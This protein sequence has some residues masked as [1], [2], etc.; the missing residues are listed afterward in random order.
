M[1][2]SQVCPHLSKYPVC[3]M[4]WGVPGASLSI[5]DFAILAKYA[6]AANESKYTQLLN[7]SFGPQASL[8]PGTFDEYTDF[9]RTIATRFH[10]KSSDTDAATI[11]ISVKGTSTN[12]DML[13]DLS[14]YTNIKMLQWASLIF[15]LQDDMPNTFL[16]WMLN[17]LRFGQDL[18]NAMFQKVLDKIQKLRRHN[19]QLYRNDT[20]IIVGHSLLDLIRES[21]QI[22]ALQLLFV[23]K[24]RRLAV[25]FQ[26]SIFM[27]GTSW[28]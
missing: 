21:Q 11:V 26:F 1:V 3:A 8:I 15:P 10:S 9:P 19:M 27:M 23:H 4:S 6:Y 20:F 5:L 18:E 16:A 28:F 7:E 13:A 14:L 12:L 17:H 2:Q 25:I 22:V 24:P